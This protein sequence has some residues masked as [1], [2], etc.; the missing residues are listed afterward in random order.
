MA[1]FDLLLSIESDYHGKVDITIL[2]TFYIVSKNKK[3]I[4]LNIL[5]FELSNCSIQS[6]FQR[7]TENTDKCQFA[8]VSVKNRDITYFST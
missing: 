6:R 3:G 5:N 8:S 1:A 2:K 7:G 4:Y